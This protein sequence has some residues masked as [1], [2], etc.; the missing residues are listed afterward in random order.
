[1]REN[2]SRQLHTADSNI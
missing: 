2:V 1:M